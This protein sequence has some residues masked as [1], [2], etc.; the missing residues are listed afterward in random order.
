MSGAPADVHVVAT[1]IGAAPA[2][3]TR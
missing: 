3:T 1:R 2:P